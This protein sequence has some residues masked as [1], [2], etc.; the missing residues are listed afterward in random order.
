LAII[1]R[2]SAGYV[3]FFCPSRPTIKT[4][5]PPSGWLFCF[6]PK[7]FI[8]CVKP[9]SLL[10]CLVWCA[11]LL[12]CGRDKNDHVKIP[13]S[14]NSH[15]HYTVDGVAG[16]VWQGTRGDVENETQIWHLSFPLSPPTWTPPSR[17]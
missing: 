5:K 2:E 9:S 8:M 11:L 10:F 6:K 16:W 17:F 4:E 1:L 7:G 14:G 13:Q 12:G 15:N 3:G